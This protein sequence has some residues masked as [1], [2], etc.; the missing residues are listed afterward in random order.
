M[1]IGVVG[2]LIIVLSHDKIS[3]VSGWHWILIALGVPLG[4]ALRDVYLAAK[5]PED[6]D[7]VGAIGYSAA[8]GT[9]IIGPLVFIFGDYI[10]LEAVVGKFGVL[11]LL[12]AC[13][14]A[15]GATLRVRLIRTAGAVFASQS[16]FVIT[17]AGITWSMILLGEILPITSWGA[18]GLMIVGLI[19][20]EPKREAEEEPPLTISQ[21]LESEA[22]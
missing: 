4:Y 6:M 10:P 5:L 3:G 19:L 18:L 14:S 16:S 13:N 7:I 8:A 21:P 15:I 17:F 9:L 2:V 12:L 20:V 11:V 1:S 22:G